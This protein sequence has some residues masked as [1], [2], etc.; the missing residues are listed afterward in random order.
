MGK[1]KMQ[2]IDPKEHVRTMKKEFKKIQNSK[3]YPKSS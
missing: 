2:K 1:I 3:K